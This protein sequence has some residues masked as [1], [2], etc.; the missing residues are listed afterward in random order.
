MFKIFKKVG[1]S[2]HGPLPPHRGVGLVH[3]LPRMDSAWGH[4]SLPAQAPLLLAARGAGGGI[5][6][7]F[8]YSPSS[9]R[10]LRNYCSSLKQLFATQRKKIMNRKYCIYWAECAAAVFERFFFAV[11]FVYSSA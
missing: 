10:L 5:S 6:I 4:G 8:V 9:E 3:P 7:A 1:Q 11:S 2:G